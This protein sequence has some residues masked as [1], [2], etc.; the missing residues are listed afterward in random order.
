[1]ELRRRAIAQVMHGGEVHCAEA[2]RVQRLRRDQHDKVGAQARQD[3]T[4]DGERAGHGEQSDRREP[5]QQR[6]RPGKQ[7]D[8]RDHALRPEQPDH[9]LAVPGRPPVQG[10]KA[11]VYGVAGLKQAGGRDE[12]EK[13]GLAGEAT[14]V[15]SGRSSPGGFSRRQHYARG[16]QAGD[17]GRDRPENDRRAGALQPVTDRDRGENEGERAPQ[18]DPTVVQTAAFRLAER[19]GFA[20]RQD[21]RPRGAGEQAEQ[22]ERPEVPRQT[23]R[24]EPAQRHG[25]EQNH[26]AAPLPESIGGGWDQQV[27]RDPRPERCREYV[28]DLSSAK[29]RN[30]SHTGQKGR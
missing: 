1:M 12:G 19:P 17:H 16:E 21:R 14:Q 3:P 18:P 22:Q 20:E 10:G 27:G 23:E 24:D 25:R 11:V 8:F 6:R 28:A 30:S 7:H 26:R 15:A 13:L 5:A 9:Q 29:P 2:R 4:G